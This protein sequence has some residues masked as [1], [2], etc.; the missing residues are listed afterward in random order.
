MAQNGAFYRRATSGY[1]EIPNL[2][3]I[4]TKRIRESVYLHDFRWYK[5]RETQKASF[6]G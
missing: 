5:L 4:P 1:G 6:F 2:E 3:M